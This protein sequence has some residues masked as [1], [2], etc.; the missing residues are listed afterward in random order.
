MGTS[1]FTDRSKKPDG[2]RLNKAI[3]ES[4][5]H[6]TAIKTDIVKKHG[7]AL[8]EWK[9][10]GPKAGWVLKVL[11]KRRNLFFLTPLK[12]YFRITFVFGDK[13]ASAVEKSNLRAAV[14]KDLRDARR[15]VEGRALRI[16]VKRQ[17]DVASITKL[18]DIKIAS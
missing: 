6:W 2:R 12:D 5:P 7:E 1:V 13:A 9:Y 14:K 18:I 15:Y 11:V 3:G 10:Y 16:E 4:G 8:E 17:K